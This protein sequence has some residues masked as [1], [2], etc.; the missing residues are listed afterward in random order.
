MS[1]NLHG[2]FFSIQGFVRKLVEL[3]R[4]GAI[5]TLSSVSGQTGG[6]NNGLHYAASSTG[7]LPVTRGF[8]R[9]FDKRG[10]RMN[11]VAPG[12]IDSEMNRLVPG[13]DEQATATPLGRWD[14]VWEEADT[15]LF[16]LSDASSRMTG[17]VLDVNGGQYSACCP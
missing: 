11:S 2:T 14:T 17:A 16:L 6:L 10:I 12:I 7:V 9:A 1:V 5:A 4:Q 8:A 15:V 3:E 13:S